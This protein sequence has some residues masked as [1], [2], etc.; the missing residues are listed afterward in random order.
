MTDTADLIR[1]ARGMAHLLGNPIPPDVEATPA[2]LRALADRL[3]ATERLLMMMYGEHAALECEGIKNVQPMW[4]ARIRDLEAVVDAAKAGTEHL[5]KG[6]ATFDWHD[7][8]GTGRELIEA[9]DAALARGEM[10]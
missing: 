8:R 5:R 9:Y 3:E 2:L 7:H 4:E 6:L 10:K 1:Q